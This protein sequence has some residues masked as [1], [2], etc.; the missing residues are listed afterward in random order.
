MNEGLRLARELL[1]LGAES[2]AA[3]PAER[4]VPA[5]E[6]WP[7]LE[8]RWQDLRLRLDAWG[9]SADPLGLHLGR[10]LGLDPPAAWLVLLCAAVEVYPEA[11]AA[12]SLLAEDER[13]HLLTPTTCARLLCQAFDIPFAAALAEGLASSA[14]RLGLVE[15]TEPVLGRPRTQRALRLAAG[16]LA[17]LLAPTPQ[18]TV[19]VEAGLER[20]APAPGTAFDEERVAGALALLRERRLL[21]LRGPSRRASRQFALDLASLLGRE[22]FFI[23][24]GDELPPSSTLLRL[25]DGLPVLDLC[26]YLLTHPGATARARAL[27]SEVR[28]DL[29]PGL[30]TL[31]YGDA[32]AV[33]GPAL[34]V[35]RL[36]PAACRRVWQ[37]SGRDGATGDALAQ[38]YRINL[39]EVRAVVAE[40]TDE[41][42]VR[43][44]QKAEPT[45]EEL[46][47][48]VRAHGARRMGKQVALLRSGARLEQLVVPR[49]LRG[50][51]DDILGWYEGSARVF[52]DMKMCESSRLGRGLTCL[53]SGPPG[54]GKTFAAQCL[55]NNLD[56]NLYR[57]DLSQV[58][59]KYIGETEKA[60][61]TVF[62]EA[63]AG[64]GILLFDEADSLFGKRS[65]VKDAHDRYANI[66]VGFLLQRLEEFDGV[67]ILATNLRNNLDPAF[68]RRM[69]FVLDFQMPD[70]AMRRRLWEQALPAQEFL[71]EGLDYTAL[72]DHF[73]LSGGG[74]HNVGLAAA[75]LAAATT[76]GCV[77]L[78]HLVRATYRELEKTGL[79]RTPAEFGDLAAL[80]PEAAS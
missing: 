12:A 29:S 61:A 70:P 39:A 42:Q 21:T 10:D 45:L 65:A 28:R 22:A 15:T 14:G 25:R 5:D 59:S 74:I 19:P 67:A 73:R 69:R 46:S 79:A 36:G 68:L 16:E 77:T 43:L 13:I 34:T 64:H 52:G 23:T 32:E 44:G 41:L 37:L 71:V 53:F 78:E 17:S 55:A 33:P 58:V 56:L 18:V 3:T 51:I 24:P 38:R 72:S 60:L 57:I 80:L 49:A 63:E 26:P 30:V 6:R 11:A 40:A 76:S 8:E 27:L 7:V 66:E 75:H 50:Q 1:L 20:Q 31:L 47:R 9:E 62:D 48:Q 4:V 2:A 35:P 54:T